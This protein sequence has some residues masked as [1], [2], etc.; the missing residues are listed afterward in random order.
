MSC[1]SSQR[2]SLLPNP[3]DFPSW[4]W[5]CPILCNPM[6]DY[7]VLGILQARILEWVAF[8]FSR[9]S[10]RPRDRTQ[11]SHIAGWFFSIM[12]P[13]LF[14]FSISEEYI[15][16]TF[17]FFLTK[18]TLSLEWFSQNEGSLLRYADSLCQ[19]IAI[20]YGPQ[21]QDFDFQF[22]LPRFQ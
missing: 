2:Q 22:C 4:K 17:F 11:V 21:G 15:I 14:W 19:E 12:K 13:P 5:Q 20:V 7:T 3:S 6:D 8:P 18:V 16:I 10:S 1:V 9:G